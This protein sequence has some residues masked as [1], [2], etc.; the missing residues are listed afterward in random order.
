MLD[1]PLHVPSCKARDDRKWSVTGMSEGSGWL[2]NV[3]LTGLSGG[4]SA[5]LPAIMASE[6]CTLDLGAACWK[7]SGP[8]SYGPM[9][10]D[11]TLG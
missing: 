11:L 1:A 2:T 5:E 3:T 10:T 4:L 6:R 8:L 7:L 9:T